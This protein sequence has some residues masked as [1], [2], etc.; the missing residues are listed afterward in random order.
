T[1]TAG[2]GAGT[3][4]TGPGAGTSTTGSGVGAGPETEFGPGTGE[5]RLG[6]ASGALGGADLLAAASRI[7]PYVV[8]TPLLRGPVTAAHGTRLLLKAEHLQ[9]GGSFKMR[10]AANAVLALAADR[11]VTGSS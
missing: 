4:V 7:A 5:V 11:V 10:G 1:G 9:L 6:V 3:G 2:R 8:R